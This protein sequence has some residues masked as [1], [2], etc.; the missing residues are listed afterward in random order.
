M[1][2]KRSKLLAWKQAEGEMAPLAPEEWRQLSG[3][4]TR[5]SIDTAGLATACP[6]CSRTLIRTITDDQFGR[7]WLNARCE[8]CQVIVD[9]KRLDAPASASEE[10][11]ERGGDYC[12]DCGAE[13]TYVLSDAVGVDPEFHMVPECDRCGG[14]NVKSRTSGSTSQSQSMP[15]F[16][17]PPPPE[18]FVQTMNFNTSSTPQDRLA[19]RRRPRPESLQPHHMQVVQRQ[20]KAVRVRNHCRPLGSEVG[21]IGWLRPWARNL[22]HAPDCA[23]PHYARETFAHGLANK[24]TR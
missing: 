6:R 19:S 5:I 23:D 1:L 8:F 22:G 4:G 2:A 9:R 21:W 17:P 12:A 14:R 16:H 20:S 10:G 24:G 11:N 18:P 13:V 15:G 3:N 7:T